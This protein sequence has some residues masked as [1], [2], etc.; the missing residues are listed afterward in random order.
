MSIFKPFNDA[1]DFGFYRPSLTQIG[2]QSVIIFD[3]NG[4][5]VFYRFYGSLFESD[6]NDHQEDK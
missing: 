3:K 1:S 6:E 4:L 2:I 5:P